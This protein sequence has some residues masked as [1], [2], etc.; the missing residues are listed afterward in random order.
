MDISICFAYSFINKQ[1][2]RSFSNILNLKYLKNKNGYIFNEY[3]LEDIVSESSDIL[4]DVIDELRQNLKIKSRRDF[5]QYFSHQN[6][7]SK[8]DI[9]N[10]EEVFIAS[11]NALEE[12]IP[13]NF[14]GGIHNYKILKQLTHTIIYSMNRQH[15]IYTKNLRKW[16]FSTPLWLSLP[17]HI[18]TIV[19]YKIVQ[20]IMEK[21]LSSIIC[22][23]FYVTTCKLDSDDNK[24]YYFKKEHW[25]SFYD[26]VISD[27]VYTKIMD[28]YDEKCVTMIGKKNCNLRERLQFKVLKKDIPK[29]H[30]ILKSKK[31]YRPIVCYKTLQ[32]TKAEKFKLKEKFTFLKMLSS[33]CQFRIEKQYEIFYLKWLQKNQPQLYF[34]KTDLMNAFGSINREHLLKILYELYDKFHNKE[35]YL[36]LKKKFCQSFKEIILE[37]QKPILIRIGS[38]IYEWKE[39]LVQ[40]YKFSPALSE[41]YYSYLDD[42][43]FKHH[44]NSARNRLKLFIRVVDDY[45]YITDSLEDAYTF[46]HALSNYKN[47]NYDKTFVN[48]DH[49]SIKQSNHIIFLGHCYDTSTLNVSRASNIYSGQLCY[50]INFTSAITNFKKFLENRIGSSGIQINS[51]VFNLLHNDEISVWRHIFITMCLAANKFCTILSILCDELDI[52][53]CF[54]IY[55]RK[56]TVKLCNCIIE[57]VMKNKPDNVLFVYCINHFRFLSYKALYLF[58]KITPKCSVLIP[59][60]K[61]ELAKSNCMTGKWR[62]HARSMNKN[63]TIYQQAMKEICRRRD[64]KIIMRE[65]DN[66]PE[67]FECYS[68]KNFVK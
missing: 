20:W 29:L 17:I 11:M 53:K 41:I 37:L 63:G 3:L 30:L 52:D 6:C 21:V 47:V 54:L 31:S 22:L 19:L 26:K 62:E 7:S 59:I 14:F 2:V 61:S 64:L 24:L 16:D 39:G 8:L 4:L 28:K 40:G 51:H 56:V 18:S 35:Q 46:L 49:P 43:Y 68:F 36:H 15:I 58:A 5:K 66:V 12:I 32:V 25:Q 42:I 44:I 50:K 55:K 9:I 13:K 48:F 23:N 34:I 1:N 57:T 67:G 27:M 60:I 38:T 10:K 65:F 33:N 45:L